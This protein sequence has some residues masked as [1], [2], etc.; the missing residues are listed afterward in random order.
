[1]VP[2]FEGLVSGWDEDYLLKQQSNP[3]FFGN[4]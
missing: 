4:C 3:R 1:M 2:M